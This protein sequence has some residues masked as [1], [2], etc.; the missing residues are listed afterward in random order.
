MTEKQINKLSTLI[1]R[2]GYYRAAQIIGVSLTNLVMLTGEKIDSVLAYRIIKENI[3]DGKL[4][5]KYKEFKVEINSDGVVYWDA[6]LKTGHFLPEMVEQ[7]WI[8][9]TPFWQESDY[10]PVET[11]WYSLFN[12]ERLIAEIEGG[13][14]YFHELKHK[15]SFNNVDELFSWYKKFYLPQ[16][17]EIIMDNFLPRLQQ[18]MDDMLD[19]YNMGYNPIRES[20]VKAL[21]EETTKQFLKPSPQIED[22]IISRLNR[23]ISGTEM[24]H[25]KSYETRHDFE[26]C[27]NGKKVMSVLLFFDDEDD[28]GI[29]TSERKFETSTLYIPKEYVNQILQFFPVRK[30]YLLYLIEDWFDTNV[31]NDITNKM[32][33][34]DIYIDKL[35]VYP[36]KANVCVPPI[37]KKPDD[38]TMDDMI[39]VIMK[40]TLWRKQ[41]L[42]DLE[43][44]EPGYIEDLYLKKLRDAETQR[45]MDS[46]NNN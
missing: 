33:R 44:R 32:G 36:D 12:G 15:T 18:N 10:T 21:K 19:E 11:D 26:F 9:A 37:T 1:R 39:K 22:G 20:I 2:V 14:D 25:V 31:F 3:N 16:V 24:Y 43:G 30:N 34:N 29:P 4:P 7:I 6:K 28:D 46:N 8:M 38:V 42:I 23:I 45:L 35:E 17:Y 40:N 41:D 13:G 5:T 27:K